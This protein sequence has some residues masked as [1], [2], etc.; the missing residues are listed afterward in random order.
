MHRVQSFGAVLGV[1]LHSRRILYVSDNL[2]P[3][4][5]AAATDALGKKTTDVL[6]SDFP[7]D[8]ID[9]R[10]QVRRRHLCHLAHDN[11]SFE[12]FY[13]KNNEGLIVLEI[14][15]AASTTNTLPLKAMQIVSEGL[16][17][18]SGCDSFQDF[19]TVIACT[20]QELTGFDS[21]TVYRVA[22][23]QEAEILAHQGRAQ[24]SGGLGQ[25]HAASEVSNLSLALHPPQHLR[26]IADTSAPDSVIQK[27]SP[28]L[29]EMTL[30]QAHL[31]SPSPTL[32]ERLGAKGIR[33]AM[34]L[35]LYVDDAMWGFVSCHS[36]EPKII[37]V[38]TRMAAEL[39]ARSVGL[40]IKQKTDLMSAQHR[41]TASAARSRIQAQAKDPDSLWA[42]FPSLAP[43]FQ[44]IIPCDGLAIRYDDGIKTFGSVPTHD[45][46]R[47]VARKLA[48]TRDAIAQDENLHDTELVLPEDLGDSAGAMVI[49]SAPDDS[50]LDL[51]F[52]RD[53]VPMSEPL[54]PD[55]HHPRPN[56]I[57]RLAEPW[58]TNSRA[59]ARVLQAYLNQI[60]MKAGLFRSRTPRDMAEHQR[61]QDLKLAELNHRVK[62]TLAL[63]QSLSR[64][65]KATTDSLESYTEALE[66]RI[67]ALSMAQDLALQEPESGVSLRSVLE[68]GMVP[69]RDTADQRV[70]LTGPPVGLTPDAT[71]LLALV[72]H[73]VITNA[74]K[75]GALSSQEGIVRARWSV[76][77]QGL[78]FE[79]HEIGS[80]PLAPPTRTGFGR[81]LIEKAIPF[82]LD[83][84]TELTFEA[85]GL[86]FAFDLPKQYLTKLSKG[87]DTSQ[88]KTVV[89]CSDGPSGKTAL[90]V[91][92]N[93]LLAMDLAQTLKKMGAA[94][95]QTVASLK[96]GIEQAKTGYFDFAVMDVNLRG[97]PC[98]PIAD[99]LKTRAIPFVFVSGFNNAVE[100]PPAHQDVPL[101]TKPVDEASLSQSLQGLLSPAP[102]KPD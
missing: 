102:I 71:P 60:R 5:G 90:L 97:A 81:M 50:I 7:D 28:E 92:D 80:R 26:I 43:T 87:V 54:T 18:V 19:A 27:R 53:E 79:W 76:T 33:S 61:H 36:C 69:Y 84:R 47:T 58:D 67:N 51:I 41:R 39:F 70:D 9:D 64:Q 21:A 30:A 4:I 22:S 32:V 42:L 83:G 59:M 48:K 95:V 23:Y 10:T 17:E 38:E 65:A 68:L 57:K 86:L 94:K 24:L 63:I 78:R 93:M 6:G 49:R 13:H 74:A 72:L 73:E 37:S 20:M 77:D 3:I 15:P 40:Q 62:N 89:S 25:R 34:A 101:L 31:C 75:H 100:M 46:I 44:S 45:A 35:A 85:T 16:T 1:D 2:Q 98:F 99:Q 12:I 52:F 96:A 66:S 14:E 91:E 88:E 56:T 8:L 82:E 29:P 11:R 55:N